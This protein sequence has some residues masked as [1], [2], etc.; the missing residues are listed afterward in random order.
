VSRIVRNEL[1]AGYRLRHGALLVLDD[2]EL[3]TQREH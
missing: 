3:P 1:L 2:D